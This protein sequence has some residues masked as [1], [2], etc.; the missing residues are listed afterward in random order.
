M[1]KITVCYTLYSEEEIKVIDVAFNYVSLFT[2]ASRRL[3]K[4]GEIKTRY[5]ITVD[6]RFLS[7]IDD[8]FKYGM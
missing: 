5:E 6:E 1:K 7:Y 3:E 2:E 4:T 8:A